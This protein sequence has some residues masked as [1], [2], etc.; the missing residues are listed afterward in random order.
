[1]PDEMLSIFGNNSRYLLGSQTN[2]VCVCVWMG[3]RGQGNSWNVDEE[4]GKS[5]DLSP[6][7]GPCGGS[8]DAGAVQTPHGNV[9]GKPPGRSP[10]PFQAAAESVVMGQG[11]P[12]WLSCYCLCPLLHLIEHRVLGHRSGDKEGHQ[13]SMCH[14]WSSLWNSFLQQLNRNTTCL[15]AHQLKY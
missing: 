11:R 6:W 10:Q 13:R 7:K 9:W 12:S 4:G 1:M 14:Q 5:A 3:T 15:P 8:A 2:H